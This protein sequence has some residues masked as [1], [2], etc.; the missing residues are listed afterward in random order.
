MGE[1]CT[2]HH[3]PERPQLVKLELYLDEAGSPSPSPA[4]G[5]PKLLLVSACD[6]SQDLVQVG[7]F[8]ICPFL[9]GLFV[10]IMSQGSSKH[11]S[12]ILNV[13]QHSFVWLGHMCLVVPPLLGT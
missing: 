8:G 9:T 5:N 7:L 6:S 13:A 12:I 4:L 10:S 2:H 11:Q 1:V 3:R